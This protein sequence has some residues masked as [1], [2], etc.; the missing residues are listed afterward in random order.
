L[1]GEGEEIIDDLDVRLVK[2][3]I[4]NFLIVLCVIV[5][6]VA[7]LGVKQTLYWIMTMDPFQVLQNSLTALFSNL[8]YNKLLLPLLEGYFYHI[9][10]PIFYLFIIR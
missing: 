2:F 9:E 6:I 4:S 8:H 1:I 10:V 5:G 7:I 3:F